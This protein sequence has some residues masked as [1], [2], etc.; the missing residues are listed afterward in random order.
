M[1]LHQ[2]GCESEQRYKAL[3]EHGVLICAIAAYARGTK[4]TRILR[5]LAYGRVH[6][7]DIGVTVPHP[8]GY[9]RTEWEGI[10]DNLVAEQLGTH[11][12][13]DCHQFF[14]STS[15]TQVWIGANYVSR[16]VAS[17]TIR[18]DR[19]PFC[20]GTCCETLEHANEGV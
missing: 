19:C 8:Q 12:C 6:A 1:N 13:L 2:N 4:S 7:L 16:T 14:K 9:D 5:T 3:N 18:I 17:N 11:R 10:L 15:M 20:Q